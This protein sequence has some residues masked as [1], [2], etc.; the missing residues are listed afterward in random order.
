MILSFYI[1]SYCFAIFRFGQLTINSAQILAMKA[2][3]TGSRVNFCKAWTRTCTFD[4]SI[5]IVAYSQKVCC[6]RWTRK[7]WTRWSSFFATTLL[8]ARI[9]LQLGD[10]GDARKVSVANNA[11][12]TTH[13]SYT[14]IALLYMW[15]NFCKDIFAIECKAALLHAC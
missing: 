9:F 8:L 11:L 10:S 12:S 14:W 4:S 1:V 7:Q 13:S 6:V 2:T 5:E 3:A 15:K